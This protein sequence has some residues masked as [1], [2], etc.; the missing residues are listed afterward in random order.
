[1]FILTNN[2]R[3][4]LTAI[5]E[6]GNGDKVVTAFTIPK[7]CV[8]SLIDE[9]VGDYVIPLVDRI[10][11]EPIHEMSLGI[12]PS[13]LDGYTPR[14]KK[15]LTYPYCYLG[16]SIPGS[17][18]IYRY[19]DFNI[20]N[21]D[22]IK[23]C[24][25]CEI[26]PNPTAYLMPQNYK[27]IQNTNEFKINVPDSSVITGYP[28]LSTKNDYFN[29]WLAQNSNIVQLSMKQE[30]FNYEIEAI[31]TGA[32]FAGNLLGTFSNPNSSIL[33]EAVNVGLNANALDVNHDYYIKNQMAQI[34]KQSMLP[35]QSNIGNSN[36]TLFG[37]F[38]F[39]QQM[40]LRYSIKRQFAERIDK[41]F[42]MY[43]YITNTVKIPNLNNRPNWNYVK[44][45]GAN[46]IGD[47][48]Q[49]DLQTI[50]NIFDNGVTLWHNANT[51]LDYSQNNR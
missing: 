15:L 14:N 11:F 43:G 17:Q 38:S 16:F 36:A 39:N 18:K 35:D 7:F 4:L 8:N 12:K 41:F 13:A 45:L 23:F 34:E 44:T 50:K 2:L 21:N 29:T 48:P 37:Y 51:F 10:Y 24:G 49:G 6:A 5:N 1:M 20:G 47:I 27:G 32:S 28:T 40:F 22:H 19:E 46:I 42:D 26:N 9:L 3:T 33:S 30:Q 31:R 25:I